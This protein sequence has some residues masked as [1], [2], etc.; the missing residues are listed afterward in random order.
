MT[1]LKGPV[2]EQPQEIKHYTSEQE[3]FCTE[4]YFVTT[5]LS[6]H[7][8]TSFLEAV[9]C[10]E[11]EKTGFSFVRSRESDEIHKFSRFPP[12]IL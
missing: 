1:I 9:F 10:Q 6:E 11:L 3:T 12:S 8:N 2:R 5:L 4:V 7:Q